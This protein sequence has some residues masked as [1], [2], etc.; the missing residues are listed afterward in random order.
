VDAVADTVDAAV[1]PTLLLQLDNW[2]PLQLRTIQVVVAFGAVVV[3]HIVT[4]VAG[5]VF[6]I[7]VVEVCL[8][9]IVFD[10]WPVLVGHRHP[11]L[12]LLLQRKDWTPILLL[13]VIVVAVIFDFWVTCDEVTMR[14]RRSLQIAP[15]VAA[16][17]DIAVMVVDRE[18]SSPAHRNG[19]F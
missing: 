19:P 17:A 14:P 7:A 2:P 1:Q 5:A 18:I 12:L 3:V 8:R 9:S 10:T 11:Q 16:D 13:V 15:V 4:L 6:S